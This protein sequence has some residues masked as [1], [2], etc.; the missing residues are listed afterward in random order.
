MK[1]LLYLQRKQFRTSC[2]LAIAAGNRIN[3]VDRF[4]D[5]MSGLEDFTRSRLSLKEYKDQR[6]Q[7]WL[8]LA[9]LSGRKVID[10]HRETS[11]AIFYRKY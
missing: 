3:D 5:F 11:K 2:Q 8:R 9:G 10:L 7:L 4:A 6:R 1:N